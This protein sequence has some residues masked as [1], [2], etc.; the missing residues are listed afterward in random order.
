MR[1]LQPQTWAMGS[2]TMPRAERRKR[3]GRLAQMRRSVATTSCSQLMNAM[4]RESKDGSMPAR[5]AL[6]TTFIAPN[7]IRQR[8]V[9]ITE[10]PGFQMAVFVG[11]SSVFIGIAAFPGVT[12]G[13]TAPPPP[14]GTGVSSVDEVDRARSTGGAVHVDPAELATPP[15]T[16][17]AELAAPLNTDSVEVSEEFLR[18]YARAAADLDREWGSGRVEAGPSVSSPP[19]VTCTD[20]QP[21]MLG[22]PTVVEQASGTE[23]LM[24]P[25]PNGI[26]EPTVQQFPEDAAPPVDSPPTAQAPAESPPTLVDSSP[27]E[28]PAAAEA[29]VQSG[30]TP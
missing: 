21:S 26:E 1:L 10:T 5:P 27:G 16:D 24:S 7:T 3:A 11:L 18:N 12:N 23:P 6:G 15:N 2:H 20:T 13:L 14:G 17:S 29:P 22:Q 25:S 19:C 28:P 4:R 8:A 30:V 9:H